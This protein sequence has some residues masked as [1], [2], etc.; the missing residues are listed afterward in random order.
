[1]H[2][3]FLDMTFIGQNIKRLRKK[4]GMTQPE[5]AEKLRITPKVVSDYET[6]KANPPT[7]RLPVIA[8]FFNIS[9]DELIGTKQI[10]FEAVPDNGNGHRH[11]NSRSAKLLELFDQLSPE[12]QRTTL[13]Q[14][15]GIIADKQ[16]K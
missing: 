13:K 7:D 11:G 15:R 5:L 14:I 1:M 16:R 3:Y 9:V 8:T 10:D 4:A 6:T 12:E 2:S